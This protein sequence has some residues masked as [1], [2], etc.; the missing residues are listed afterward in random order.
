[1]GKREDPYLVKR[2][3]NE[4]EALWVEFEAEYSS[5]SKKKIIKIEE[6]MKEHIPVD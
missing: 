4:M 1:M 5:Q 6:E 3:T 2:E